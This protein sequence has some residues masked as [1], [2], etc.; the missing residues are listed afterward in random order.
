MPLL[1]ALSLLPFLTV[2][3]GSSSL[4][5]SASNAPIAQNAAPT[6]PRLP[7]CPPG[8]SDVHWKE[9]FVTPVGREGLQLTPRIQSLDGKRVRISGYMVRR[10]KPMPG[11]LI[12]TQYPTTV[13]ED[14]AG[15]AE[16]PPQAVRVTL[17]YAAKEQIP[18]TTRPMLLTGILSVGRHE[19]AGEAASGNVSWFRLTLDAPDKETPVKT[20]KP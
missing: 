9:F 15:F 17:P 8:V 16:L 6:T 3:K 20:S 2:P 14:E 18:Y 5:D 19:D 10:E 7:P 4:N 1:I 12:L 13:E 11:V